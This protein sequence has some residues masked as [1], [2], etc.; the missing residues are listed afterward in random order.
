MVFW[1]YGSCME[2]IHSTRSVASFSQHNIGLHPSGLNGRAISPQRFD[3]IGAS[4]GP[5]ALQHK[6]VRLEPVK[7]AVTLEAV[8]TFRLRLGGIY[9]LAYYPIMSALKKLPSRSGEG[10]MWGSSSRG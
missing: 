6:Q 8:S 4:F 7:M 9:Q 2:S 10:Y 1:R 3:E 5:Q